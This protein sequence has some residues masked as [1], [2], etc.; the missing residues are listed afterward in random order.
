MW[1]WLILHENNILMLYMLPN[2]VILHK[3]VLAALDFKVWAKIP[4]YSN[5]AVNAQSAGL[6][7]STRTKFDSYELGDPTW[8]QPWYEL[9]VFDVMG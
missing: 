1:A 6:T 7:W 9:H 4:I 8:F 3:L 2:Q 5:R